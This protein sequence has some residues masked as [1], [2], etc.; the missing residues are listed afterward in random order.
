[1]IY[2]Y[3]SHLLLYEM[4]SRLA[5]KS[6][7]WIVAVWENPKSC[8]N[9][10]FLKIPSGRGCFGEFS[11][12]TN[13]FLSFLKHGALQSQTQK[14]FNFGTGVGN[15]KDADLMHSSTSI[16]NPNMKNTW[17]EHLCMSQPFAFLFHFLK[18]NSNTKARRTCNIAIQV[19]RLRT[20][21]STSDERREGRGDIE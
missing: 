4:S 20:S 6:R 9:M 16:S 21:M 11:L 8:G 18:V 7:T 19:L 2:F 15:G 13:R 14:A 3:I 10:T 17:Y 12:A 5:E 1:M